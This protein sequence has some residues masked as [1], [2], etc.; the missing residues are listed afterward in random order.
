[1]RRSKWKGRLSPSLLRSPRPVSME[2][3]CSARQEGAAASRE[4]RRVEGEELPIRDLIEDGPGG[5]DR[6]RKSWRRGNFF[7]LQIP[8]ECSSDGRGRSVGSPS[9]ALES[10]ANRGKV[11]AHTY[12]GKN[13]PF[14]PLQLSCACFLLLNIKDLVCPPTFACQLVARRPCHLA[15]MVA[16]VN[17]S[18]CWNAA[19]KK[20]ACA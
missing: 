15:E 4:E 17:L 14:R 5:P 20:A 10:R 1:M 16:L 18:P 3:V 8:S 7:F 12:R 2:S 6:G 9:A 19:R 13:F 11:D